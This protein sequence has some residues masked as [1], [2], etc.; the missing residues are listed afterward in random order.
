VPCIGTDDGDPRAKWAVTKLCLRPS[1]QIGADLSMLFDPT[2]EQ[3]MVTRDPRAK[4]ALYER[5]IFAL[6]TKKAG[7]SK[8]AV[9]IAHIV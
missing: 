3:L 1:N 9:F 8:W 4:W 2:I 6:C 7:G 5:S